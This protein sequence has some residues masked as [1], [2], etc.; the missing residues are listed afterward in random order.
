MPACFFLEAG[1]VVVDDL[2]CEC[3]GTQAPGFVDV[4]CHA[5]TAGVD[6]CQSCENLR[7]AGVEIPSKEGSKLRCP[8]LGGFTLRWAGAYGTKSFKYSM[9]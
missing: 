7:G 3:T 8:P 1:Y 5:V 2:L 6:F 9:T 4:Y